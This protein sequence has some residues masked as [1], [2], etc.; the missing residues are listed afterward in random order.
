MKFRE[1]S[2][3]K[4]L[5][6]QLLFRLKRNH[7]HC[8]LIE[9]QIKII[10]TKPKFAA[11]RFFMEFGFSSLFRFA[12]ALES[13]WRD[14]WVEKTTTNKKIGISWNWTEAVT[15]SPKCTIIARDTF[16]LALFVLSQA[17]HAYGRISLTPFVH[18]YFSEAV[19]R[20]T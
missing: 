15:A 19:R 1:K 5:I 13:K 8:L 11:H 20:S 12:L 4:K 9:T 14:F 17:T 16:G 6:Q 18:A 10:F 3:K 7:G 2:Y